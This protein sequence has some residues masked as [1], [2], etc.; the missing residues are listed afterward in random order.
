MPRL[1]PHR[2]RPNLLT[3]HLASRCTLALGFAVIAASCRPPDD[4][5]LAHRSVA[6]V[7]LPAPDD[8]A[9]VFE[10]HVAIDPAHPERIVAGAQ[11][12]AG[13]NRGGLRFWV[14]ASGDGGRTWNDQEVA[15]RTLRR[16]PTMAADLTLAFSP[17]GEAFLFGISGDSARVIAPGRS[18]PEAAL[19]L[20]ASQDG[21]RSFTPRALLGQG[22]ETS[23]TAFTV[24][25]K[26]WMT[27]DHRTE[28]P[29]H[30]SLYLAWTRVAVRLDTEPLTITR[31]LV[32]SVSRDRG[33]T[34]SPP[35]SIAEEGMGAQ[36]AVRPGGALDVLW[37]EADGAPA[38]VLHAASHD[39]GA[40]FSEPMVV[41]SA[42]DTTETLGLPTLAADEAG[43]L[44]ACWLRS[45]TSGTQRA[46]I[47]C[48]H[49]R[50]EQGWSLPAAAL[51]TPGDAAVGYPALAATDEA[52]WLLLYQANATATRV[53]LARSEDGRAFTVS[54]TLASTALPQE[55]FCADPMLACRADLNRFTPGDYVALAAS[56]RRL[57]AAYALP[58]QGDPAGRAELRLSVISER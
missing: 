9:S 31:R 52:W 26:P 49:Y 15:P 43:G 45:Y 50:Q 6:T 47:R 29:H 44:L 53:L 33:H 8:S 14:W 55:G 41:E 28:S 19:A 40:S 18:I 22:K 35:L 57:A 32:L 11:Y 39:G 37:L 27:V 5:A 56:R 51:H 4:T 7:V 17:Q 21:G 25:D 46:A 58:R 24:S 36:L 13:Y 38:R 3:R 34:F 42:A 23:A 54:D 20:A 1:H 2:H 10:P 30:G 16:P 48:S 12:G